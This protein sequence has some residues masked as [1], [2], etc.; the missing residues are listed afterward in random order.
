MRTKALILT[1]VMILSSLAG[2]LEGIEGD[3]SDSTDDLVVDDRSGNATGDLIYATD[4]GIGR[5][6]AGTNPDDCNSNGG[7]WIEAL[8]RGGESYCDVDALDVQRIV[9]ESGEGTWIWVEI[10]LDEEFQLSGYGVGISAEADAREDSFGHSH[11]HSHGDTTHT[12]RHQHGGICDPP[13]PN[14]EVLE[15]LKINCEIMGGNWTDSEITI[16][17]ENSSNINDDALGSEIAGGHCQTWSEMPSDLKDDCDLRGGKLT[18]TGS[19][20]NRGQDNQTGQCAD[21]DCVIWCMM[22]GDTEVDLTEEE[23]QREGG[24]WHNGCIVNRNHGSENH[25]HLVVVYPDNSSEVMPCRGCNGL[26]NMTVWNL[27]TTVFNEWNISFDYST[28]GKYS[29][30][31][32]AI[33]GSDSSNDTSWHWTHYIWN[34]TSVDNASWEENRNGID[35]IMLGT[36]TNHIAWAPNSTHPSDIPAPQS[37]INSEE[38]RSEMTEEDCKRRGGT[39]VEV[40]EREGEYFCDYGEEDREEEQANDREEDQANDREEEQIDDREEEGD[41]DSK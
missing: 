1:F 23:C 16:T 19:T 26:E 30:T 18:E 33:N 32:T 25:H 2:C 29:K 12:H 21:W 17:F 7:T 40:P 38:N 3:D 5:D 27:T 34:E 11:S 20:D 36:H 13:S 22:P 8:E 4:A 9:C 28:S 41:S 15:E 39:W 31:I 14:S 6:R 24:D 37:V 10:E 35:A